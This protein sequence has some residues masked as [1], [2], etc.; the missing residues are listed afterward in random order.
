MASS[1]KEFI[2][3]KF[4]ATEDLLSIPSNSDFF[5]EMQ[6]EMR[7]YLR[8]LIKARQLK[9]IVMVLLN[10]NLVPVSD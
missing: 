1:L 4:N 6:E 10:N 2:R 3:V 9:R 8:T 7:A 5:F